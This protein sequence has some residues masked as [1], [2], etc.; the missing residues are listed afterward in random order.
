MGHSRRRLLEHLVA[1]YDRH[2]RPVSVE[3]LASA[4]AADPDW[5]RACLSELRDCA[6][7]VRAGPGGYRPTTTGRELLALDVDCDELLIVDPGPGDPGEE[8][9]DGH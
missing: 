2:D 6:L 5:V 7:V 3:E 1:A 9:P 8:R 4:L